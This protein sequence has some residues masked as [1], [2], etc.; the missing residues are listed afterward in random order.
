M[1]EQ[2][3]TYSTQPAR[4]EAGRRQK[5]TRGNIMLLKR[6]N[7]I[8]NI[9]LLNISGESLLLNVDKSYQKKSG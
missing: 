1:P 6:K 8:L 2:S 4:S 5:I 9:L 7:K 3:N